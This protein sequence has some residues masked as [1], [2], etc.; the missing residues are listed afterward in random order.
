[1]LFC[2]CVQVGTCIVIDSNPAATI[3]WTKNKSPLKADEKGNAVLLMT[4]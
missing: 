4:Y 2:L 1:M 3:T